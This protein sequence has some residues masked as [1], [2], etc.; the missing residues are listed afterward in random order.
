[1]HWSAYLSATSAWELASK[2][3]Y[4][5]ASSGEVSVDFQV[6]AIVFFV[7]TRILETAGNA[8]MTIT[9]DRRQAV[10][11]GKGEADITA[12][13]NRSCALQKTS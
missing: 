7:F 2:R 8:V 3:S 5:F 9:G 10:G 12:R 1:L 11:Q 4:L 6:Y 13:S